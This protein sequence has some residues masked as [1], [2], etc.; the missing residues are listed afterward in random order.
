MFVHKSLVEIISDSLYGKKVK[1]F[2]FAHHYQNDISY[3][4]VNEPDFGGPKKTQPK[5]I[6]EA[7]G[8]IIKF[9]AKVIPYEGDWMELIVLINDIPFKLSVGSVTDILIISDN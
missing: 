3:Y 9:E 6:G 8:Q 7:V 2:K 4:F 1:L 5:P